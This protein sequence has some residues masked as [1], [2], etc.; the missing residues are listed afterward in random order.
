MKRRILVAALFSLTLLGGVATPALAADNSVTVLGPIKVSVDQRDGLP[1]ATV[2]ARFECPEGE[3]R[4][5]YARIDELPITFAVNP[6]S[7]TV[8]AALDSYRAETPSGPEITCTGHKQVTTL[9]LYTI[10]YTYGGSGGGTPGGIIALPGSATITF[11]SPGFATTP[12]GGSVVKV[13]VK[14]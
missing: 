12:A 5:L 4:N 11:D 1:T 7:G 10:G 8:L 13:V 2:K 14:G 3:T 9:D 6:P